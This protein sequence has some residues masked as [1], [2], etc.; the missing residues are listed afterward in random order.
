MIKRNDWENPQALHQNR[1]QERAYAIPYPDEAAA[2]LGEK[3]KSS[4]YL[5]LNG[6]WSFKY[7]KNFADMPDTLYL[8]EGC[9]LFGWGKMPVPSVWQLNDYDQPNYINV[10]YPF[11]VDPPYLPDENPVGIYAVDF[12]IADEWK[13]RETY[14]VFE[15]VSSFFYLYVN[16]KKVGF[17][18]GSH[19]QSQFN[20]TEY[21]RPGENRLSVI[22][23]KWCDGSY[24]EDQDFFRYSG[25]F[26]DV[27]LLSRPKG[28]LCDVFI[29]AGADGK[30]TV[31]ADTDCE[32]SLFDGDVLL[33]GGEEL[34]AG[35]TKGFSLP[36]VKK[37]T[38]ETPYLYQALFARNG[39]YMTYNV[40]FRTVSVSDKCELLIN[41]RAVKLKGVNRHDTDPKLGYYTPIE[42]MRRD[43]E[44]MKEININTIRCSHYPNHPEF[45]NL[46]DEYGF[47][48]IDEADLE[49]HGFCTWRR[50]YAYSYYDSEWLTDKPEWREA[51]VERA[52]R[53]VER[54][55]NHPCIIMW[56]LGNE[57]GLGVNHEAMAEWI[58]SRDQSRLVHY[59]QAASDKLKGLVDVVS[60]MYHHLDEVESHGI[61]ADG[62]PRPYFMCEY[63]HAMGNGPGELAEYWDLFD[64]YPRLIGGCIWEWADHAIILKGKNG[65][66]YYG[67]GG[68]SGDFP[69]DGN[70]CCDG[71]VLPDRRPYPGTMNVKAIYQYVSARFL[72]AGNDEIEIEMTNRHDFI[73]LDGYEFSWELAADGDIMAKGEFSVLGLQP[74]ESRVVTVNA[75]VP[76]EAL[77]GV[78]L[79][80]TSP[81]VLIQLK[82]PAQRKEE[83]P[84]KKEILSFGG[85]LK[86][87]EN[88]IGVTL[89]GKSFLYLFN[90]ELGAFT[91]FRIEE[92]EL[93]SGAPG[94]FGIWRAPTDN[95]MWKKKEWLTA[96]N[97]RESWNFDLTKPKIY[98]VEM[99]E[100]NDCFI[101]TVKSAL[102]SASREPVI[103]M[104][105]TYTVTP[106]GVIG[107]D[108]IANVNPL[109]E[110]LPRFGYE[111]V[112]SPE[113]EYLKWYGMGP[114]ECYADIKNHVFMGR[115]ESTVA[116][117]YFP[118][119]YPQ[120]HGNH[121]D[122]RWL[123]ITNKKGL[124]LKIKAKTAFEFSALHLSAK[125]LTEANHTAELT[126]KKETFLRID[127]KVSGIGT[128]ACGPYTSDKY[129]LNEKKIEYGFW[130]MPRRS[131]ND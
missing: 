45:Y 70:F 20:L 12:S 72:A 107:V 86:A 17:S 10:D 53:M 24:L 49:M 58:K 67:Y 78:Y 22:V 110:M 90:K 99:T 115:H 5:S 104:E 121:I 4:R 28:H 83:M 91:Y 41:G 130:I 18:K 77:Y 64:K 128:G 59:E 66:P 38:A 52:S 6:T 29:L 95:D 11:P 15:G 92:T 129:L 68:D 56:S 7:F 16:G 122:V 87:I 103:R 25:I 131:N 74:K 84:S 125:D 81:S 112:L 26:R 89:A 21:L 71:L 40:G 100:N 116:K 8:D 82:I 127:Y 14:L 124:G 102:S 31:T 37:W 111:L 101:I 80:I 46:C 96:I 114:D 108:V 55:K 63:A 2:L 97:N 106:D 62:D 61:N 44:L 42:H 1:E 3:T 76:K 85:S 119:I 13:S 105:T 75:N 19:M 34:K 98:A 43:L 126:T 123:L 32:F 47:Y 35:Q 48:V 88:D 60:S 36:D 30:L 57:A 118:Y 93:L 39:E 73:T 120:E 109:V 65:R 113:M 33:L 54:D 94:S 50:D 23:F 79:K 117:Q 51:F 27:Y 69:N 9:H